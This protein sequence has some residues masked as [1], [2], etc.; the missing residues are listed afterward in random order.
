[1]YKISII[2]QFVF[3]RKNRGINSVISNDAFERNANILSVIS[4]HD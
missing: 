3:S 2:Y 1:M 4:I